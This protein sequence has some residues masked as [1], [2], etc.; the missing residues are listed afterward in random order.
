MRV[1]L[2][3]PWELQA[4]VKQLHDALVDAGIDSIARWLDA[5][6]NTY[7]EAWAMRCLEDVR[8]CDVFM[9]WNPEAWGRIGTGGRHVELGYALALDKPVIVLGAR[10]NIFHHLSYVLL[11]A[12]EEPA[13]M[14][15]RII[16]A[17]HLH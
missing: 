17:G 13:T 11:V 16:A 2:A 14:V 3:S 5:D 8:R 9:L 15:E 12:I 6:D 7:T 10:T 1:Y 4:D